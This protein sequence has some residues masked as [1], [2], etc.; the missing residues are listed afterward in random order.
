MTHITQKRYVEMTYQTAKIRTLNEEQALIFALTVCNRFS[1]DQL[2]G[3][4][5]SDLINRFKNGSFIA[6]ADHETREAYI[7]AVKTTVKHGGLFANYM[8]E[9]E[10]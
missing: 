10:E 9:K 7:E 8:Y 5:L 4:Y 1:V 6:Y 2:V 3:S